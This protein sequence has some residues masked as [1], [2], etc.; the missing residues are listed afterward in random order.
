M[1]NT[2]EQQPRLD[3]REMSHLQDA[4][5]QFDERIKALAREVDGTENRR[6]LLGI[7]RRVSELLD[8]VLGFLEAPEEQGAATNAAKIFGFNLDLRDVADAQLQAGRAHV[9]HIVDSEYAV[10]I[11][12]QRLHMALALGGHVLDVIN[13]ALERQQA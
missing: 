12:R 8:D 1:T 9:R 4:G 2:P 10:D 11:I 13:E 3:L 7:A 5:D 6:V